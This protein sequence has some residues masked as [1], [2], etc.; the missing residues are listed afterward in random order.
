MKN[1][2]DFIKQNVAVFSIGL[3]CFAAYLFFAYSGNRIC[4]CETTERYSTSGNHRSPN[5]FYRSSRSSN[6]FYHK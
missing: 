6:R 1:I 5:T 4:D 2:L 3:F